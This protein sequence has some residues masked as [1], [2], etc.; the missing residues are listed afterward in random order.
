[1]NTGLL[2]T[3]WQDLPEKVIRQLQAEKLRHYLN[4]TVLPFSGHYR[5]LFQRHHLNVG[6]FRTLMDLDRLPFTSKADLVNSP[7]HP[8]KIR[9]FILTP[10]PHLLAHRPSTMLRALL[11]GRENVSRGFELEYRPI[12]MTCTTGRSADAIAFLYSNHDLA[13]LACAGKRIFEICKAQVDYRLLNTFPYAPH[14]AFWLAHYGG[15]EFNNFVVSSG[16]GRVLGTEGQLRLMRQLQPHVFIGMPTFLYHVMQQA[17]EEGVRCPN[18]RRIVLGGEKA[19]PGMRERLARL[20]RELGAESIDVVATYG[21]TEA[22]MAW[23]ECPCPS[24]EPSG[25]HLY[26]DLGIFEVIDPE[27][28]NVVPDGEPG[29]LVFTPLDSR[30]SVVLRY[31]TGDLIDGGIIYEPCPHCKRTVP[32]L[33]GNISR[34]S[35]IKTMRLDK[36]KGT[37]VDFNLLEHVLDDERHLDSWQLELRKHNDDPMDL[38]E[39]ILHVHK[40]DSLGDAECAQELRRCFRTKT[41]IQPNRIVFHDGEEMS[42]LLGVGTQL[43][44]EKIV[45]H[46]PGARVVSRV[47]GHSAMKTETATSKVEMGT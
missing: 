37:L 29:E 2:T 23:T 47:N 24:G 18:L 13:N 5:E 30:G 26:P 12:F 8:Q 19:A 27:T 34:V 15:T 9:E 17:V 35:E 7:E 21:F 10:D 3:R 1:M 20:A 41:E 42:R 32:R 31:R 38:D 6:S 25:Y 28:G 33:V 16:G 22:K 46:R 4:T 11:Y 40:T 44:E 14:L 39:L 43:K 36:I 45:D